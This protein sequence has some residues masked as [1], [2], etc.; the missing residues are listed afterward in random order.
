MFQ[1]YLSSIKRTTLDFSSFHLPCFNSTLVQ[2]K[3]S[4]TAVVLYL[5]M[6]FNSTL[7]QLKAGIVFET[8]K[9][10]SEFQFYLSSIKSLTGLQ[11]KAQEISFNSTLV[12]L[13]VALL[14]V[15]Q[16]KS[17]R[18][19]FYLSSIKSENHY[20]TEDQK[21]LFQFYLSSIKRWICTNDN[22]QH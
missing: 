8:W 10:F 1:F 19:Q 20:Q 12:Q 18:F 22:K 2:L 4:H 9:S 11:G 17:D 5:N 15:W 16:T 13:K 6:C 21:Y 3:A 14:L 7:V